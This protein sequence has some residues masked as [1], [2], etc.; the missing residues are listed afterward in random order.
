MR[1]QGE[2]LLIGMRMVV[3]AFVRDAPRGE[4][5]EDRGRG[6]ETLGLVDV[7][8]LTEIVVG[9]PV[10]RQVVDRKIATVP[11]DPLGNLFDPA[12][13]AAPLAQAAWQPA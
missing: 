12:T 8:L 7:R 5:I 13:R 4:E 9:Q 11:G 3:V 10:N 1:Y 2:N 6:R